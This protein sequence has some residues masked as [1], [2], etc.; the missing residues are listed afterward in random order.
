M[1][2]KNRKRKEKTKLEEILR[3][4][5][6]GL[7][8]LLFAYLIITAGPGHF[9]LNHITGFVSFDSNPSIV[10]GTMRTGNDLECNWSNSADTTS[11][12][13]SWYKNGVFFSSITGTQSLT[14]PQELDSSN[15]AKDELWTCNV[16]LFNAT[17]N[18]SNI[19]S[20]TIANTAPDMPVIYYNAV[21][22]ETNMT[23]IEDVTYEIDITSTDADN[24]ILVYSIDTH[25]PSLCELQLGATN[26][27]ETDCTPSHSNILNGS[28]PSEEITNMNIT[29]NV[30]ED[31]ASYGS[32]QF[33]TVEFTII[34][35]NDAPKINTLSDATITVADTTSWVVSV[36]DEES[37]SFL[38][39]VTAV[40][41]DCSECG[42]LEYIAVT[43][44]SPYTIYFDYPT[45]SPDDQDYGNYTITLNVF[46]Y[47]NS[48]INMSLND[49]ESFKLTINSINHA[50]VLSEIITPNAVQGDEFILTINATDE[51]ASNEE[52]TESLGFS[53]NLSL[54]YNFTAAINYSVGGTMYWFA[55]LTPIDGVL[56]ND[57]IA[58][59]KITIS[60]HDNLGE[61]DNQQIV[62][63]FNNTNDPPIIYEIS[64]Y[65]SNS[66]PSINFNMSNIT[67]YI[68]A[69]FYYKFNATDPDLITYEDEIISY[70]MNDTNVLMNINSSGVFS[71]FSSSNLDIGTYYINVTVTDSGLNNTIQAIPFNYSRQLTLY[72]FENNYPTF[73]ESNISNQHCNE[74]NVCELKINASDADVVDTL[75]Y[76]IPV[77]EVI[78]YGSS[79]LNILINSST[80][81]INFTPTQ[82]EVGN[83]TITIRVTDSKGAYNETD[84]NL[85]IQNTNDAPSILPAEINFPGKL[86]ENK[87]YYYYGMVGVDEDLS[88]QNYLET[89]TFSYN[90]TPATTGLFNIIK[91]SAN[92]TEIFIDTSV[93][94]CEDITYDLTIRVTDALGSFNETTTTFYIYPKGLPPVITKTYPDEL[95]G[96]ISYSWHNTESPH[97][98]GITNLS[99]YANSTIIFNHSTYDPDGDN[100]SYYWKI[101]NVLLEETDSRLLDENNHTLNM[102]FNYFASGTYR[103]FLQVNDTRYNQANW[104]WNLTVMELNSAPVLLNDLRNFTEDK[105]TDAI[106]IENYFTL[107]GV[108][109]Y[110]YDID[111]DTYPAGNPN[112]L[113]DYDQGEVTGFNYTYTDGCDNIAALTITDDSLSIHGLAKGLCSVNFTATDSEGLN[114]TSNEVFINITQ[115]YED[116]S[117]V[118]VPSS[119]GSGSSSSTSVPIITPTP[120]DIPIALDIITA[121]SAVM[122]KNQ[123]LIIPIELRNNWTTAL[124][125]IAISV[126]TTEDNVTYQLSQ[127][128]FESIPVG[129]IEKLNLTLSNYR[130]PGNYEIEIWAN[131]SDPTYNDK[132]IIM[133]NS[134][135]AN[136]ND[137]SLETK[138]S[139]VKDFL[140]TN[141]EC[142]ELQEFVSLAEESKNRGDSEA[143][144]KYLD[145]AI[146]GCKYLLETK[147]EPLNR[148]PGRISLLIDRDF[149]NDL[150]VNKYY[151]LG[152]ILFLTAIFVLFI[153]LRKKFLAKQELK[154]KG[155]GNNDILNRTEK[156]RIIKESLN[157]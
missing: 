152:V 74:D 141:K 107:V 131:V 36:S 65:S 72:V 102:S 25:L 108:T 124:E 79:S 140:N 38:L 103:L 80:G 128:Y 119:G 77:S 150:W 7:C 45:G 132:A 17:N 75:V 87:P 145:V 148:N 43:Q 116:P 86:V 4:T 154:E 59:N 129:K 46:D 30:R 16:T 61:E 20:V 137:E 60:V 52:I 31:G 10:G 147:K 71:F 76:S 85:S 64:N 21:N 94:D 134:L 22:I 143:A 3:K 49:T 90:L 55:N 155:F 110:F 41:T 34:P 5:V 96:L 125:G 126:H 35:V 28:G 93:E 1:E 89:L 149:L 58:N 23:L 153:L 54:L 123:T 11:I 156:E 95:D 29:F 48:V 69:Q 63:D 2:E 139:F 157:E 118:V 44:S 18:V 133:I 104:T 88:A 109:Q 62:T 151:I 68:G 53:T 144:F 84:Y 100:L 47:T 105:S 121:R 120:E 42:E 98:G 57:H 113:I 106:T 39:N 8:F 67:A 115:K 9:S 33:M 26:S 83:Y 51:D 73:N 91:T 127:N 136:D 19:T 130:D 40:E 97:S 82:S 24:D 101:N 13:V 114:I 122:Y 135:E 99:A 112:Q 111:F 37:D 15:T 78:D 92:T 27:G 56:T 50:P 142:V 146:N 12:T 70:S 81:Q 66:L 117:T 32:E 14:N 138:L 6:F